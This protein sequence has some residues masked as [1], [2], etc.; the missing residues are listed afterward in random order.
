MDQ[1]TSIAADPAEG[2]AAAAAAVAV[3]AEEGSATPTKTSN[4]GGVPKPRQEVSPITEEARQ[5]SIHPGDA[6]IDPQ[7][8]SSD[9]PHAIPGPSTD[10]REE[11]VIPTSETFPGSL[12]MNP[13]SPPEQRQ[14]NGAGTN[15]QTT[16]SATMYFL[17]A[18]AKFAAFTDV[19]LSGLLVP[20]VPTILE[21]QVK[22]PHEHVQVWASVFIAAYGGAFAV[23]S[24]LMPFLTRQ[25]PLIWVILI[26][27]LGCAGAAFALIQTSSTL[28]PLILA[29]ALQGLSA[30][31]TTGTCSG[32]LATAAGTNGGAITL[33]WITTALIQSTALATGP[34]IAAYLY[35][36]VDKNAVFYLAYALIT[37]NVL[38][39]LIAAKV[40][41]YG[42]LS[43]ATQHSASP[44][45]GGYGT[46]TPDTEHPP[47]SPRNGQRR[48]DSP[49]RSRSP[50][51]VASAKSARSSVSTVL[52]EPLSWTPRL[53][54]A[55]Y[56][57][58]VI[59]VITTA[60]Q[61]V[62]PLF[63]ERHFHWSVSNIGLMFVPLAVPA[64]LVGPLAGLFA[65]RVPR[66]T[67]FLVSI[68]FAAAVPSLWSLGSFIGLAENTMALKQAFFVSLASLSLAFGLIGDPLIKEITTIVGPSVTNDPLSA[69]AQAT[70]IPNVVNAWGSLVGPLL[71]GAIRWICGWETLTQALAVL[72]GF[73]SIVVFL[74]LQGLLGSSHAESGRHRGEPI[75]DEESAPLLANA[76]PAGSRQ[77]SHKNKKGASPMPLK[78]ALKTSHS[79]KKSGHLRH[80]SVDNMSVATTAGP[81][82]VDSG[83]PHVR[84][85]AALEDPE[86]L[87]TKR[88]PTRESIRAAAER[89]YLMREAPHAPS[90]DPLLAA[91]SRYVLDEERSI[92]PEGERPK[93]HVVV[94]PEGEAPPELL[95]RHRHHIVAINALDG[96]AQMV[97]AK[98]TEDHAV[99]VTEEAGDDQP[100]F[101]EAT[102][103]RYVV[104]VVEEGDDAPSP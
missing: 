103:R 55:A 15:A 43:A 9:S 39:S 68:G 84:F 42:Q 29:R 78:G 83:T 74:F 71:A 57:Y 82:S 51:S 60:L 38:L 54:V 77:G 52:P 94:F 101:S 10:A 34:V 56:G 26:G 46:I 85:Q 93:R 73:T 50:M 75:D 3:A 24:P 8:L 18:L 87:T 40:I 89:R 2:P 6:G 65:T 58:L 53:L 92:V 81:G 5:S 64:V 99:S 37:S 36:Y 104:V 44:A 100:E 98:S 59:G 41:P 32:M 72:C 12:A 61:T 1:Q 90:T 62:L 69:A 76:R 11:A 102:S 17:V 97:S 7:V 67:R 19:F 79:G 86:G 21:R 91:G 30:A 14:G 4:D 13:G 66:S 27:G 31:A 48:R 33:S 80:F 28:Y 16:S 45:A 47:S 35:D 49:S 23:V 96:T 88:P 63:V 22:V 20:L 95:E 25:G 70:S